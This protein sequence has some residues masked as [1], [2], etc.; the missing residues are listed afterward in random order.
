MQKRFKISHRKSGNTK[1][2][3]IVAILDDFWKYFWLVPAG[4]VGQNEKVLK[5]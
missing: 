5:A 3:E 1:I 4:L 2:K